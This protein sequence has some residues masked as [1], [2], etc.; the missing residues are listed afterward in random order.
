[1]ERTVSV[2]VGGWALYAASIA[3]RPSNGPAGTPTNSSEASSAKSC[4]SGAKS[5]VRTEA[6]NVST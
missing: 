3:A 1:M 5:P 4:I 6:L 2:S